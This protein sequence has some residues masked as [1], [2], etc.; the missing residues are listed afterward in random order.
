VVR[1]PKNPG[2]PV[3]AFD[4]AAFGAFVATIRTGGHDL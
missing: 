1:D 4:A 2:G 3:L